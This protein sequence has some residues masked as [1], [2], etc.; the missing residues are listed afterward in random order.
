MKLVI[1]G[2]A[3]LVVGCAAAPT[4][5][6]TETQREAYIRSDEGQAYINDE[7][8]RRTYEQAHKELLCLQA[9]LAKNCLDL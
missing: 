2:I 7:L 5:E 6:Q 4:P 9:K 3:M 1:L 8:A